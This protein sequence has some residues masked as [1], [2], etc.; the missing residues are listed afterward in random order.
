MYD[1]LVAKVNTNDTKVPSIRKLVSKTQYE[2]NKILKK[3]FENIDKKIP[4]IT[5]L[6]T[7]TALNTKVTG[8]ILKRKYQTLLIYLIKL[9]SQYKS[10]KDKK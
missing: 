10:H 2:S 3:S 9:F 7:T 4:S 6:V 8:Y 5:F 1:K